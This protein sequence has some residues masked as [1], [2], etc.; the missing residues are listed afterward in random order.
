MKEL[1]ICS[2]ILRKSKPTK[3]EKELYET[4][5]QEVTELVLKYRKMNVS[6]ESLKEAVEHGLDH[7]LDVTMEERLEKVKEIHGLTAKKLWVLSGK[8]C[9][10]CH[11]HMIY[12]KT[13]HECSELNCNYRGDGI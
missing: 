2:G 6:K 12:N 8:T 13:G 5:R 4:V 10:K 3:K 11:G 1:N 7:G 9:P